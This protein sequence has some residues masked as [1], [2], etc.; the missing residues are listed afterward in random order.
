M[1]TIP[2]CQGVEQVRNPK[3]T[4]TIAQSDSLFEHHHRDTVR[5]LS[6]LDCHAKSKTLGL[7]RFSTSYL[8][9][10]TR[11][12]FQVVQEEFGLPEITHVDHLALLQLRQF[13]YGLLPGCGHC[14]RP[15]LLHVRHACMTQGRMGSRRGR[16]RYNVQFVVFILAE[17]FVTATSTVTRGGEA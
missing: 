15:Q 6:H 3:P 12:D 2:N 17:A 7:S 9:R 16:I 14:H 1:K 13:Q 5:V 8:I 4:R 11:I 10:M